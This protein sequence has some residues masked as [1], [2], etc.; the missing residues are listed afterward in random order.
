[1]M[2]N[3]KEWIKIAHRGHSEKLKDNSMEAFI[4]AINHK[5]D[6][7]EFDVQYTKDDKIVIYHDVYLKEEENACKIS[8]LTLSEL[9]KKDVHILELAEF[10]TFY[11]KNYNT[12][13]IQFYID[14]KSNAN[15]LPLLHQLLE[16]FQF[17]NNIVLASFNINVI[18]T[19]NLL[20]PQYKIGFITSN[21]L[22]K[23]TI[24]M[25]NQNYKIDFF[26][27]CWEMINSDTISF[28]QKLGKKV[29]TYTA[30]F[31]KIIDF[32]KELNSDGI[33]SNVAFE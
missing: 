4:S 6:M 23:K 13:T 1:M 21:F 26:V 22:D 7:I 24:C 33:I 27:F 28:V 11:Y 29:Y 15:I 32:I 20:L 3:K 25:L 8:D 14:I 2:K 12:D 10:F 9:K 5:F 31:T 30:T 19:L 16:K 18:E 17:P